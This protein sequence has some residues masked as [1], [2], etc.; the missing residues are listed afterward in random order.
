MK[1]TTSKK[2]KKKN[3][4]EKKKNREISL[5]RKRV[6]EGNERSQ[7]NTWDRVLAN[8]TKSTNVP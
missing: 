4:T 5:N 2:K 8:W 7:V 3:N 1:N 6:S